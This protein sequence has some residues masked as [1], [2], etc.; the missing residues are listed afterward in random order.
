MPNFGCD[1]SKAFLAPV[2]FLTIL[3]SPSSC[4]RAATVGGIRKTLT[5]VH[6]LERMSLKPV[7]CSVFVGRA[8]LA[9]S[10]S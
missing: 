5:G 10:S 1:I 8:F 2:L 9:G 7:S 6:D 3:F 4:I